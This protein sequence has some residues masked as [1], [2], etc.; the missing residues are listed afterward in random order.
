MDVARRGSAE[1]KIEEALKSPTQL[2]FVETP[3]LGRDRLLEGL[4]RHRNPARHK[5]LDEVGVAADTPVTKNLKGISLRSALRLMLDDVAIDLRHQERSVA[6][7]HARRRPN[8]ELITKVY[9]VAD[10]VLPITAAARRHGHG[11]GR[12]DGRH[13]R[14]GMGGMGGGMGGMGGGMGGGMMGGGMGGGGMGAAACGTC[15]RTSS[16]CSRNFPMSRPGG[17]QAFCV[18]DDLRAAA[19]SVHRQRPA[20]RGG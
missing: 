15:R 16:G 20:V 6:D 5:A 17:F 8:E 18:I 19:G 3:L 10:L 2:D 13:G 7:H 9:P 4:A 11:H 14:H 12:H 1:K